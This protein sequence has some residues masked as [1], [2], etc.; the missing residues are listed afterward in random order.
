MLSAVT[1]RPL[2]TSGTLQKSRWAEKKERSWDVSFLGQAP[3][4]K[5]TKTR[6]RVVFVYR[7]FPKVEDRIGHS[8]Q[9]LGQ[10]IDIWSR[11]SGL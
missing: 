10:P 2:Y 6:T 7:G 8:A 1:R 9:E 3:F 4:Q 11:K 5:C